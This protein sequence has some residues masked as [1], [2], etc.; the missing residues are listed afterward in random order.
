MSIQ[1]SLKC[2]RPS[3][4]S[5][6]MFS[7]I[8]LKFPCPSSW[9]WEMRCAISPLPTTQRLH[10][11]LLKSCDSTGTFT[12]TASA[13][14]F[15][16]GEGS[17]ASEFLLAGV[18]SSF[19]SKNIKRVLLHLSER[20]IWYSMSSIKIFSC[21]IS[22]HIVAFPL[23][24]QS[25]PHWSISLPYASSSR[26]YADDHEQPGPSG[27]SGELQTRLRSTYRPIPVEDVCS[28]NDCRTDGSFFLAF[29]FPQELVTYG[30]NGQVFSN[31]AQVRPNSALVQNGFSNHVESLNRWSVCLCVCS[32][33]WWCVT[34]VRWQRNKLWSCTV[35]IPW[36]CSPACHHRHV[37]SSPTAW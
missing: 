37:P 29:Q 23:F 30:G 18:T 35:V 33:A 13:P 10:R 34:W 3:Y 15:A 28:L 11:N 31:W 6:L 14:H 1:P 19:L 7:L 5:D 27:G 17:S 16:W 21:S 20:L 25:L 8:H 2:W 24:P 4:V 26:H 12:C 22:N 36:V 9:L 32:S